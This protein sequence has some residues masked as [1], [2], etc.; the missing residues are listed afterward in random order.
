[1]PGILYR[2][3]DGLSN[4]KARPGL[5]FGVDMRHAGLILRGTKLYIFYSRVGD[6]PERILC[7]TMDVSA[8]DWKQ[9]RPSAPVEVLRPELAWEGA[10]LPVAPSI[11]GEITGQANQLRDPALFADE[12]KTWLLYACAGEQAIAIA[13]LEIEY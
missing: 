7:S 11:R 8:D 4:F 12:G 3:Q 9:W 5:L 1:M 6:A 13:E 10:D 2:S